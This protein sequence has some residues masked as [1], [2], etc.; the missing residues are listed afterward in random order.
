MLLPLRRILLGFV[1]AA[2]TLAS[3]HANT[4]ITFTRDEVNIMANLWETDTVAVSPLANAQYPLIAGT[5]DFIIP[6]TSISTDGDIHTD[7]ATSSSGAGSTGNNTGASPI[8]CEVINASSTDLS[9]LSGLHNLQATFRGIF[10][11]YTEHASERHFE[12]HPVTQLQL[13]NGVSFVTDSDYHGNIV[14]D[15]NGTTHSSTTL[16]SVIDG[17]QTITAAIAADNINVNFTFPSPSVNYGQ[18][19]GVTLTALLTDALSDYFLFKPNLLPSATIRCRLVAGSAAAAAAAGLTA[20]QSVTVNILTR[21]D[22]AAVATQISPMVPNETKTFGRPIEFIVLG[23]PGIGPGPT[24]TPSPTPTPTPT[25][26]PSPSPSASPTPTPSPSPTP[27]PTPTPTA[28]PTP[29]PTPGAGTTFG[30]ANVITITGAGT[31]AGSPYPSAI[32]VG[33]LV[34]K[35]TK[36]TAQLKGVTQ[37]S[38]NDWAT[39]LDIQMVG[40]GGQNVMLISD[41]GGQNRFNNVT[42]TFDDTAAAAASRTNSISTGSYKPTNYTG[43]SDA[44]PAPAPAA[45][46]GTLLS[47][48]NNLDPN[49][50]WNLFVLD[51][52]SSGRGSVAG[53]WSVTIS[54][55]PAPPLVSTGT[56]SPVASTTATVAGTVDPL[57]QGSTYQFQLGLD[58]NYGFTQV[59][60]SAG[61]GTAPQTV[62]L[63][64]VGLHPG[65]TYHYR[66]IGG[67]SAGT[68]VG[69]DQTFTTSALVDSDGDGLP[70]DYELANGMNP[71]NAADAGLDPDGDGMTNLQEYIAGTDPRSPTSVLRIASVATSGGDI[72]VTFPTVLGKTYSVEIS[73]GPGGPWTLLTSN[74]PGT[75]DI[76]S[77]TDVEAKDLNQRR[78]YHVLV[79]P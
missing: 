70:N 35:I 78:Y 3:A 54:T 52:F 63:N 44:F 41:A 31:G 65:T 19:V 27:T 45:T 59:V 17:S 77:V 55:A 67:N 34:G 22:M 51:Q 9:H 62:T 29:T 39:D 76:L 23:L 46:P 4:S 30:N 37:A 56:A 1:L 64:L 36:V 7:M 74:L 21:T 53:G 79:A 60:Q 57:G 66:L 58:T 6:H 38:S 8:V 25:P 71:N 16:T 24:P 14:A 61:S 42:L 2:A 28:T 50:T 12:L 32:S 13:W 43:D 33:G 48:Y 75:G 49:G 20:N 15:P 47:V 69:N 40:P 72:V 68:A 26:T 73:T 10:R 11:F 5:W 18:Y